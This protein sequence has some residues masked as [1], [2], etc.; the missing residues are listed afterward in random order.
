MLT[1]RIRMVSTLVLNL[2]GHANVLAEA[3]IIQTGPIPKPNRGHHYH[4][5]LQARSV[6]GYNAIEDTKRTLIELCENAN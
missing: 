5:A 3:S 2:I 6:Q 1:G 4:V